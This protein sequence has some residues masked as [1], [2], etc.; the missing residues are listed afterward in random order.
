MSDAT[1]LRIEFVTSLADI[2]PEHWDTL[3][4][5]DYPFL[6]HSFLYGLER[7]GCTSADTGWQPCHALLWRGQSLVA[8]LPLY[9]KDHSWGEYVFDWAWADAWRRMGLNYYPK[10]V[11]AIPFTPATGPRLCCAEGFAEDDAWP[12]LLQGI[13]ALSEEQGISSWHL[14]FPQQATSDKLLALGTAQRVAV[15][16]HWLNQGYQS[17]DDF[18]STFAS[19]KRKNLRRERS[20][21]AEQGITLQR[22]CGADI[23][24]DRWA[25]FHRFYQ[26]TYAKRSGHGGYLSEAFFTEV[27]PS[28]GEQTMMVVAQREGRDIA[29]ALYFR[30]SD[31]LYGRFWGCEQEYDCLHFE[32]CYYQGIEYC[33][34]QGLQRFDPGAQGEHKIQRGFTPVY[35]FSNHWIADQRLAAAVQDFTREEAEHVARYREE[36]AGLLPFR[37]AG[38]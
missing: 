26:L 28:L 11:S 20:R 5:S 14:L 17:F 2:A 31:T 19:R 35:T 21:V 15:Q 37:K 18:L 38:A 29:A 4:G 24:P 12:L 10:L 7:S 36:A 27:A 3:A 34:E 25:R 6:R 22:L 32:A 8:L 33:I 1:A 9:L 16:F 13:R 30:S 23:S